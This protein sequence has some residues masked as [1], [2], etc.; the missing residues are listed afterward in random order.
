MRREKSSNR[1]KRIFRKVFPHQE[2]MSL[3]SGMLIS[4]G[5][6]RKSLGEK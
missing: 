4:D 3:S 1:I 5:N 6:F 2:S